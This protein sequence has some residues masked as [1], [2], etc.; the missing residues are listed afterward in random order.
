MKWIKDNYRIILLWLILLAVAPLFVEILFIANMMGVE[1]AFG[2][3]LLVLKDLYDHWQYRV[4]RIKDFLS[5]S[6]QIIQYHPM[7][8]IT[9]YCFHVTVSVLVLFVSGSMACSVLVWYP[10]VLSGG[11]FT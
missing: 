7:F 11:V 1:V 4:Q 9:I 2:F 10:I 5:A 8:Q 3:L 6:V